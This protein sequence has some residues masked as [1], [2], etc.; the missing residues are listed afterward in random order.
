MR[1]LFS[2]RYQK[3]LKLVARKDQ[4]VS[5]FVSAETIMDYKPEVLLAGLL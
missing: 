4:Q 3:Q 2:G 5:L 1:S